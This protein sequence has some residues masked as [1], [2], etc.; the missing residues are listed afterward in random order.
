MNTR[1]EQ[2]R[3]IEMAVKCA[4]GDKCTTFGCWNQITEGALCLKCEKQ[5][6]DDDTDTL[7][8]GK[9]DADD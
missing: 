5:K 4:H 1:E 2:D 3:L 9:T 7:M 8:E 6:H